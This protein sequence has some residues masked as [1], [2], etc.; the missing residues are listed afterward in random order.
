[1][2]HFSD[3]AVSSAE[4]PGTTIR[5]VCAWFPMLGQLEIYLYRLLRSI[6]SP[7]F[8][9]QPAGQWVSLAAGNRLLEPTIQEVLLS[10]N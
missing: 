2:R 4:M 1:M 10:G 7:T 5:Q 6:W 8:A 3:T 9:Y